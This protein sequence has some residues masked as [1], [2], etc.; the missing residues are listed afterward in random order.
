MWVVAIFVLYG[1]EAS[2]AVV[3]NGI[4]DYRGKATQR[5]YNMLASLAL[6]ALF[7]TLGAWYWQGIGVAL[8]VVLAYI[9]YVLRNYWLVKTEL[10]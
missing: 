9:P 4:L 6:L 2:F 1:L 7:G 5:S 10:N 3:I 8:A